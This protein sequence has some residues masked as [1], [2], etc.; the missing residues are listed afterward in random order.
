MTTPLLLLHTW[1]GDAGTWAPAL[2]YLRAVGRPVSAPD[3]PGH[4]VRAAEPFTLAGAVSAAA[5]ARDRLLPR[6]TQEDVEGDEGVEEGGAGAGRPG[7]GVDVVGSGLGALVALAL[8]LD[9]PS[10]VRSLTLAG[11]PPATGPAAAGRLAHTEAALRRDGTA[12]FARGYT[13]ST[14]L[15]TDPARRDLL[16]RSMAATRPDTLLNSL[17]A[18]LGWTGHAP[19]RPLGLP[20]LILRGA[21]DDRISADAA[22]TLAGQLGGTAAEVPGAGHLAYLDD[23][24]AFAAALAA[25]HHTLEPAPPP[26]P[27][28]PELLPMPP[29]PGPPPPGL[30]G[31]PGRDS[32][33]VPGL[34]GSGA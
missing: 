19:P 24:S 28:P 3:L 16:Y 15:S 13:D 23:P 11:F 14:L 33:R 20:C 31:G 10:R 8:A 27:P 30:D 26:E 18:T 22:A 7:G 32:R 4:G 25:F 29:L 2:P 34:S 9:R 21:H 1:G 17:R 6:T 12:L 5:A